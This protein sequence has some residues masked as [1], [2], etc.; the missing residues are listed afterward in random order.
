[1]AKRKGTRT[2]PLD[3]KA[4]GVLR[5]REILSGVGARK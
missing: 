5:L 2:P 1:M 3:P 4:G